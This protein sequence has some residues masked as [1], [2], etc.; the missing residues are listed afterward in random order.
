MGRDHTAAGR[1][2]V[3]CAE[4]GESEA[5]L[6]CRHLR[7]GRGLRFYAIKADPWAWCEECDAVLEHE[8]GWSDRLNQFADWQV[9][10]RECY[11]RALRRHRLREWVVF[12]EESS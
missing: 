3:H 9:Y 7:T 1:D 2:R 10:C 5:C 4:H 6:L 8:Q 11:R 12:T